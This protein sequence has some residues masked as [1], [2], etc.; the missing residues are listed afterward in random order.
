MVEDQ[1]GDYV[2][3]R[4]YGTTRIK[5]KRTSGFTGQPVYSVRGIP[6]S[7]G[8]GEV[9]TES[10]F[11]PISKEDYDREQKRLRELRR[12]RVNGLMG[13]IPEW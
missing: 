7:P 2:Y 10:D 8:P 11:R 12:P 9:Y 4:G 3:M 5:S 1:V 13:G 6:K